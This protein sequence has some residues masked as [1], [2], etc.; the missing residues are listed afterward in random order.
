MVQESF[1]HHRKNLLHYVKVG[2]G[3]HPLLVFH[4]FGQDHT[5]YVPLTK[6]LS[7]KYTLYI[8]DLFFHGK[9]EWN[10]GER[11]IDKKEWNAIV[12]TLLHEQQ[13][14]HFSI[15]AYSMGGKFALTTLEGFA[16]RIRDLILIAPDGIKT[17]IWY[18]MATYPKGLRRLFK[19]MIS[20]HN[21]FAW[22]ATRLANSKLVD[23]GLIR[24]AD[25][26]MNSEEKR[27][28]VYYSWVVFRHLKFDVREIAR[29]LN[30]N[31]IRLTMFT[32]QHDK[33]IQS[34]DMRR[35]LRHVK[36]FHEEILDSGHTGLLKEALQFIATE[37]R[38]DTTR[39]PNASTRIESKARGETERKP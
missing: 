35:L 39:N 22:I 12:Q 23:R 32:G 5:L 10:E 16:S 30:G 37:G 14:A 15:L 28:R 2:N 3:K 33:V 21:R 36:D 25:F 8:I 38:Y 20:R 1:I 4:G 34:K 6:S 11:P 27:R 18:S 7:S 13:I 24:F 29:L 19:S 9:S 31:G 26:Q 17:N